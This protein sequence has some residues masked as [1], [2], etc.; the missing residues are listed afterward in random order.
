MVTPTPPGSLPLW[1]LPA[2]CAALPFV[3]TWLAFALSAQAGHIEACNP[4][5]DG[6]TSISRAGR[7]G[8]ANPLFRALVLPAAALQVVHWW[9]LRHW[10]REL[11]RDPGP[12]LTVL[13]LVAGAFL[14]LYATFLGTEG[15]VYRMLR[16]YGV[17]VYFAATYLA[18]L[19][20]MRQLCRSGKVPDPLY[21][22][23]LTIALA[24]L[25]LGVASTIA[26]AVLEGAGARDRAENVL[27]WQ[28]GL[29]LTLMFVLIA[30]RWRRTRMRLLP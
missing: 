22:P 17:T 18:L 10:L 26:S 5:W 8:L 11:G 25:A 2:L 16:R 3:A 13:G 12:A 23:L 7:H 15:D 20:A 24:M 30:W 27:E 29:W 6:C 9:L 19:V 21:R 28:L 4:F 1:P 14:A